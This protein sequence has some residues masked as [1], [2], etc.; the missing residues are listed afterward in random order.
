MQDLK[1]AERHWALVKDSTD[2]AGFEALLEKH[3]GSRYEALA[4][5]RIE[6]LRRAD[7]QV[8]EAG[9]ELSRADRR[10]IQLGLAAEG[11]DPGP[12]DGLFGRGTR[13]AIGRWQASR[14]EEA[15]GHLGLQSAKLLLAAGEERARREEEAR[16]QRE[17]A[18]QEWEKLG[19]VMVRVDGGS[20]TMGLPERRDRDCYTDEQPAHRVRVRSFEIGKYEVTQALWEAVMGENPSGFRTAPGVP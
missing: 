10:L 20:F 5:K 4:R 16:R 17:E 7:P 11:F 3:P 19:L 18:Q 9:L 6:E 1:A 15:T 8:V 12:A 2:P 14:G 13:G